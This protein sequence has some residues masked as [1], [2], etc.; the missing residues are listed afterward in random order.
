MPGAG[1]T[2]GFTFGF[3]VGN[4]VSTGATVTTPR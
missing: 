3:T 2:A 1:F 4:V